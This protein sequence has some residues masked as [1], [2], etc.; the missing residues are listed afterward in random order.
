LREFSA[1]VTLSRAT[2]ECI[3]VFR[4]AVDSLQMSHTLGD[5]STLYKWIRPIMDLCYS[6]MLLKS[7]ILSHACMLSYADRSSV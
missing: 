4:V 6:E 5:F 3:T 7:E 2:L 1:F